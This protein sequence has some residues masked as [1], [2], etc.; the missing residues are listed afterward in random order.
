MLETKVEEVYREGYETVTE[1]DPISEVIDK[2]KQVE[3]PALVVEDRNGDETG[4]LTRRWIKRSRLDPQETSVETL[5]RPIPSIQT[6]DEISEA[7]RLMVESRI[8]LLSVFAG[9]ALRGFISR[10]DVIRAA[11]DNDWGQNL[12][13]QVMTENPVRARSH[14]TIAHVLELFN[15]YGF[16]H[17]PVSEN[18][19]LVGVLSIQDLIDIVYGERDR[20]EGRFGGTRDHGGAGERKG[21]KADL[22]HMSIKD[23]MSSPV[24]AARPDDTLEHAWKKME[25]YDISSL[26]IM[27]DEHI[28]G[29]VTKRDL[30]EPIAQ[31]GMEK[32]Q[33]SVQFS[34]KS[35]IRMSEEEKAAM[36][37]EFES[38]V[39]RYRDVVGIGGLFVYL[40]MYG[41][42]S[43]GDQLIQCR[44]QFRTANTQYY[45]SAEAW[46]AEEAYKLALD[47][48]ERQ[49]VEHKETKLSEEQ[50]R[51]HVE[52]L[53]KGEL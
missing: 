43:K 27:E 1:D 22:V 34:V 13:S 41:P 10:D 47:R 12:V 32:R 17:A 24:I 44:L 30:L 5:T 19:E 15:T 16:S 4:V 31:R 18:D 39:N 2:I 7:A 3:P 36:R 42:V 53:L 25:E 28:A 40:R 35:G 51:R 23:A 50:S 14:D 6:T 21:E 38:F 8:P 45:S 26:V 52:N 33:M 48:L 29:I 49:V 9:E 37:R 11:A 46:S 20:Q